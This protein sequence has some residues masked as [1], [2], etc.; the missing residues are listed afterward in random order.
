MSNKLEVTDWQLQS[1]VKKLENHLTNGWEVDDTSVAYYNGLQ[2]RC[3]L[4][5]GEALLVA[6]KVAQGLIDGNVLLNASE[7]PLEGSTSSVESKEVV[8]DQTV[9]ETP[10]KAAVGSAKRPA[11]AKVG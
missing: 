9:V 10:V 4:V 6:E 1:F 7:T 3:S 5:K 11:K 2:F 8:V